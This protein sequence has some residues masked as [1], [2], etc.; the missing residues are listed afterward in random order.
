MRF[1]YI[2]ILMI[3]SYSHVSTSS[4]QNN[5]YINNVYKWG[6][7][8]ILWNILWLNRWYFVRSYFFSLQNWFYYEDHSIKLIC[9]DFCAFSWCVTIEIFTSDVD[10]WMNHLQTYIFPFEN[11]TSLSWKKKLTPNPS[12]SFLFNLKKYDC[13]AN[14]VLIESICSMCFL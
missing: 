4:I 5:E 6:L 3:S 2:S 12:F 13:F 9:C 7:P 8:L 1:S 10:S 11:R 14:I